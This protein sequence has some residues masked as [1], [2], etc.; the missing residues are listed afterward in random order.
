MG[1]SVPVVVGLFRGERPLALA[2]VGVA[3]AV[4]ALPLLSWS[5]AGA[6]ARAAARLRR[7]V[8]VSIGTGLVVGWFLVF[9]ARIGP[10]AG[11]MP[12]VVGRAV[13]IVA[14]AGVLLARRV[15]LRPP[16]GA[17]LT[18]SAAGALDSTANV[19]YFLA[20]RGA[21]MALVSA[22]VSLAPA[23]TVLLARATLG[24]RW[25][26]AQRWGLLLALAAG[27]CISLK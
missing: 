3:L 25:S 2:W 11:L 9:V 16:A 27:V 19:A 22:I 7:T 10:R 6:G 5:G 15:P 12:L 4:L 8:L 23:T 17:A 1:L 13:A 26:V 21:P 14:L 18:S 20:V 24:E